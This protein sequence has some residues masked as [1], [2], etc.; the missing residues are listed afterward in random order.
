MSR[1]QIIG[2]IILVLG[3]VAL[4]F[5]FNASDTPVEKL[6]ETFTGKYTHDTMMYFFIGALA[7]IGG[8]LLLAFGRRS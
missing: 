5:A 3:I 1:N 6:S 2:A 7:T 4:G 8:G